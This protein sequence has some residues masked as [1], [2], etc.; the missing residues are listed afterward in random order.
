M[1]LLPRL[2]YADLISENYV[3]LT[4]QIPS[5]LLWGKKPKKKQNSEKQ[6]TVPSW[7]YLF[8]PYFKIATNKEP[9]RSR[10]YFICS[11][12]SSIQSPESQGTSGSL[13][14][15]VNEPNYRQKHVF[16]RICVKSITK[17]RKVIQFLSS[18]YYQFQLPILL[19]TFQLDES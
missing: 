6:S 5:L 13:R 11:I 17:N 14:E 12:F 9:F 4:I 7:K 16:V 19:Q 15:N 10:K 8:A 2:N 18:N 3:K 1:T